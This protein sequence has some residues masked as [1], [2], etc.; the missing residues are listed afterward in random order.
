ME[1]VCASRCHWTWTTSASLA[2][3][4]AA[5]S[6]H[7][8]DTAV[9]AAGSSR[10]TMTNSDTATAAKV[11]VSSMIRWDG[12]RRNVRTRAATPLFVIDVMGLRPGQPGPGQTT[13]GQTRPRE[14]GQGQTRPRQAGPGQ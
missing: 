12:P 13:P 14:T 9:G 6:T 3:K 1:K 11:A 4:A 10:T 8:R 2:A 5:H 7:G